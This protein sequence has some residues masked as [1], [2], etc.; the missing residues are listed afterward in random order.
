MRI[1]EV[2]FYHHGKIGIS[3]IGSGK[4]AE[5]RGY[6]AN[7]Y[8]DILSGN[9]FCLGVLKYD[10]LWTLDDPAVEKLVENFISYALIRD[11]YRKYVKSKVRQ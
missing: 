7:S 1:S 5:L 10:R 3:N 8:P 2:T 4:I 9:K 6:V 11:E